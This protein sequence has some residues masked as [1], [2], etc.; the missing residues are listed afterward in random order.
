MT[1]VAQALPITTT[2]DYDWLKATVAAWL[3]RTDL[4]DQIPDF[5]YLAEQEINRRLKVIPKEVE[6][7]LVTVVGDR[8]VDLPDDFGSPIALTNSYN[9]PRC[10]I[11]ALTA[12]QLPVDDL[13]S[14]LPR[15]WAIDGKRIAFNCKADQAYPLQF[16]Y[17][18]AIFLTET[19]TTNDLFEVAPDLYLYGAL[20]QAAP[21]IADDVRLPMWQSK[22]NSLMRSV[23]TESARTK[24]MVSLQTEIPASL[25]CSR[26][27]TRGWGY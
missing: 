2:K 10:E 22:F 8:F 18:K 15:Y 24:A 27:T 19:A 5:I 11:V 26:T 13:L 20:V 23:A 14:T 16:R 4:T 25:L 6:A 3:H 1:I 12:A 21:Y 9:G 7:Q 17:L